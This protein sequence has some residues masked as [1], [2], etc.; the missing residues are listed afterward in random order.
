M[1]S[2]R[3]NHV[4]TRF[5]HGVKIGPN[6]APSVPIHTIAPIAVARSPA[7]ARSAAT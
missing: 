5:C 7:W 3:P 6:T 1:N 2:S 4:P